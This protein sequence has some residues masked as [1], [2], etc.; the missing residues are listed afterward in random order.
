MVKK[1][2]ESHLVLILAHPFSL[3][4]ELIMTLF[5]VS[6]RMNDDEETLGD[7]VTWIRYIQLP[8]KKG[9]ASRFRSFF[10]RP[11]HAPNE[12]V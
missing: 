1:L 9:R 12:E 4:G 8:H 5:T 2:A 11:I 10:K 7:Q 3:L 6:A